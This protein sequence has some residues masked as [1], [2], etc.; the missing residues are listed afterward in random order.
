[1]SRNWAFHLREED[2]ESVKVFS[3]MREEKWDEDKKN[4][5]NLEA[6]RSWERKIR[7][8]SSLP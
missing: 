8:E 5:R 4:S 2:G 6:K 1:V 3:S 7:L